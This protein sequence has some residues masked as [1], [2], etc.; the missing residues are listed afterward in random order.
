MQIGSGQVFP[1]TTT[2]VRVR[3]VKSWVKVDARQFLVEAVEYPVIAPLLQGLQQAAVP[4]KQGNVKLKPAVNGRLQLARAFAKH[5]VRDR[6]K[7]KPMQLASA[8]LSSKALV[9]D[10]TTLNSSKTNYIF[11]S[12]VTYY[13]SG[14]V[15][16]Y[17]SNHVLEGGT[18]LK[19]AQN[20]DARL[21]VRAH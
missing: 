20:A 18:V 12:D 7:E 11:A 10:Y 19:Y 5:P 1:L 13:I 14:A 4:P 2:E 17:G 15:L 3:T 6:A 9:W 16:L 21:T 8:P